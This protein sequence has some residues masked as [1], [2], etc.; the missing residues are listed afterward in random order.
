MHKQKTYTSSHVCTVHRRKCHW[1]SFYS[2]RS[3][4]HCVGGWKC[5]YFYRLPVCLLRMHVRIWQFMFA[6]IYF[7]II[8]RI[9]QPKCCCFFSLHVVYTTTQRKLY[10][11]IW[12]LTFW[13]DRILF[14][15][16]MYVHHILYPNGNELFDQS[17]LEFK[18]YLNFSAFAFFSSSSSY[19]D[20]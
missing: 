12:I 2:R 16:T 6:L 10:W 9:D 7:I 8:R 4:H 19:F 14:F 15:R 3:T 1:M 20:G 17:I 13:I 18:F 11:I 5:V